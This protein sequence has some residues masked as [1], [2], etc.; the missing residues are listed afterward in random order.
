MRSLDAAS[1]KRNIEQRGLVHHRQG[2]YRSWLTA[3]VL[4]PLENRGNNQV[5]VRRV[6][7]YQ[8]V[9]LTILT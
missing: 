2:W 6:L 1:T 7:H 4:E 5:A 8:T 9:C 3:E